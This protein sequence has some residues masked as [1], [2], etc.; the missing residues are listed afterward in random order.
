MRLGDIAFINSWP[1]TYA[2]AQGIVPVPAALVRGT[3]AQLNAQLLNGTLDVSAVS[4]L[5]YLQQAEEWLLLP[6]L[7]IGSES[8]VN[9]VLLISRRP[10][11]DLEGQTIAVTEDGATTPVLLRILLEQAYGIRARYLVTGARFPD[12]LRAYPAALVIG[13]EALRALPPPAGWRAGAARDDYFTWDLGALWRDWTH[14]PMVYAVW[15][16]RRAAVEQAPEQVG[17][18]HEALVASKAWGMRHL[19]EVARA[20]AAA[21]GFAPAVIADYFRGIR[22]DLDGPALAGLRRYAALAQT[23]QAVPADTVASL[24]AWERAP[25]W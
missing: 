11:R 20:A 12:V 16:V 21:A 4:V 2:A 19:E 13:D 15:A 14:L 23:L 6:E 25:S 8:G 10:L 18:L 9:S 3:P 22:Y 7:A 17:A 24:Q 1:V 5:A